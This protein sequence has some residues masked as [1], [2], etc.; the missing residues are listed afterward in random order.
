MLTLHEEKYKPTIE[1]SSLRDKSKKNWE[2][3]NDD[4]TK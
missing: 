2:R 1:N 4:H 3:V